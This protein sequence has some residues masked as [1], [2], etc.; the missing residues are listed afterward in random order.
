MHNNSES[1]PDDAPRKPRL[2]MRV[3]AICFA[4]LIL[5]SLAVWIVRGTAYA[6]HCAPAAATCSG[7]P[8]GFALRQSLQIA[9]LIPQNSLVLLALAFVAAIAAVIA[10][11]VLLGALTLIVAPVL[12]LVL[13]MLAVFSATHAACQ[14]N[15]GGVGDCPLWGDNMGLAFHQAA[16]V[17]DLVYGFA[18]YT[19]AAALMLWIIGW[20]V[21][22]PRERRARTAASMQMP[23][24]RPPNGGRLE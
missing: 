17:N 4:A 6:L 10:H 3:W 12:S 5:P 8:L 19:F 15:D 16:N 22:R 21:T 7:Y 1:D 13:P 20:F 11:R 14:V 23:E 18:P 9:W 2:A 24:R